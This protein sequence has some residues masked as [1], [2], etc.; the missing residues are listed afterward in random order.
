MK[1]TDINSRVNP[2]FQEKHQRSIYK[3]LEDKHTTIEDVDID[4]PLNAKMILNMGPQHPATH[5]VLRLVLQLRGE[6]IEKTKLDIGY[7][8]R[9]VEKIAENKTYQ[10]FMPYTDRMDYLSPYSNNVA[11]CTAVE[12]IAN[13][14][15]PD[16]AHYIRMIG[17]ELARISSHLLWLGTMVMDAGAISFF[18]WTFR[19]REKIYDIMDQIAG[20]RFTVSHSRIGGVANDL[21]SDA[22]A[23][24][25]EFITKF[26]KELK[27]WHGLLDRNRIFIDRNE[28]VGVLET[29][30]A[31]DI[32]ATGPVLRASGFAVD[33]R[34]IA[35]YAKYDQVEFEVP[36]R[37]EGDNLAR[38]FVRMEEMK[39][40]IRIIQQCLDKMP[41]GPIRSNNAK[42][43]YPS[44]DEVYYSMEGMI[45]DFMMTDT[46]IC[47]P[48]GAECYHAVESPKGELGYYIQSDG[49]GHPWRIKINTPSFRNLQVLEN[50]LDGEM[51][52]DTVVVIGG[53][54]PVMGEADK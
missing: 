50:I 53:V 27:D 22:S 38:Y 13:V 17:C 6:T 24:I 8:H 15:V 52:A 25:K 28:N 20:H 41:K 49:T 14:E 30:K 11:L 26:P 45:H 19:E 23:I 16:R 51:V 9:G 18:I 40:S 21:T 31:L 32:G 46:G 54:D 2:Q 1:V 47:P 42:H 10:E 4:D 43:A 7:L 37:L 12:K 39:E 3:S 5:G 29:D 33:Q 36:T 48:E 44:K 34:I 35:P